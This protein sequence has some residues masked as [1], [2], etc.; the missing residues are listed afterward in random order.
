MAVIMLVALFM[1]LAGLAPL[2]AA[3]PQAE[4]A[5]PQEGEAPSHG[6]AGSV[7]LEI[8][9]GARASAS[10]DVDRAVDAW[11]GTMSAEQR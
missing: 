4:E 11:I 2:H 6:E 8:P 1:P 9:P 5:V 10:F 3:P 7:S